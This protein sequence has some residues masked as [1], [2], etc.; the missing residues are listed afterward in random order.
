LL[1]TDEE[2]YNNIVNHYTIDIKYTENGEKSEKTISYYNVFKALPP[3]D[4]N[5]ADDILY[6]FFALAFHGSVEPISNTSA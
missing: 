1:Y 4:S 5:R 6:S 2:N 3:Y